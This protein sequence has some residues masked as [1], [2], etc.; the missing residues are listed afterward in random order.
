MQNFNVDFVPIKRLKGIFK[1]RAMIL[2]KNIFQ[3][4]FRLYRK[5]FI[6]NF[7][8]YFFNLVRK[9]FINVTSIIQPIVISHLNN[10]PKNII[11]IIPA[12]PHKKKKFREI[13]V[14]LLTRVQNLFDLIHLWSPYPPWLVLIFPSSETL[15]SKKVSNFKAYIF[16]LFSTWFEA[17]TGNRDASGDNRVIFIIPCFA[18]LEQS[19]GERIAARSYARASHKTKRKRGKK[20]RK[21]KEKNRVGYRV[22]DR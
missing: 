17:A 10:R 15:H 9:N 4:R 7:N 6:Q 21:K 3:I 5:K 14:Y 1:T 19:T 18:G 16:P 11:S 20:R 2:K 13:S 8:D 22:T 12:N